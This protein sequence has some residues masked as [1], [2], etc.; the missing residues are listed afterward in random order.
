MNWLSG[1]KSENLRFQSNANGMS[2][3][4]KRA[5]LIIAKVRRVKEIEDPPSIDK[6]SDDL[7]AH[8]TSQVGFT[9]DDTH[10]KPTQTNL[11]L[12]NKCLTFPLDSNLKLNLRSSLRLHIQIH[13]FPIAVIVKN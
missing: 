1:R 5:Q 13:H 7:S 6:T 4:E 12:A 8:L 2:P 11:S 3:K 10:E 9:V